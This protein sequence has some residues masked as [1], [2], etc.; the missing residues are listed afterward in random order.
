MFI[1][2]VFLIDGFFEIYFFEM[3]LNLFLLSSFIVNNKDP[4]LTLKMLLMLFNPFQSSIIFFHI[5]TSHLIYSSNQMTGFFVKFST[6][7]N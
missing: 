4:V 2:N 6:G 3:D 1:L 5:E 7:L